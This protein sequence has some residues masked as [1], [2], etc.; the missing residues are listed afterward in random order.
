LDVEV[1]EGE[2]GEGALTKPNPD[3]DDVRTERP[4]ILVRGTRVVP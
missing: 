4:D 1:V 3:L 2:V